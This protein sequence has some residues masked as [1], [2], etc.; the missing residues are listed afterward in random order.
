MCVVVRYFLRSSVAEFLYLPQLR[1]LRA[2]SRAPSLT[3]RPPVRHPADVGPQRESAGATSSS[4]PTLL[5]RPSSP[6][7][8][9]CARA[10]RSARPRCYR[11]AAPRPVS[12]EHILPARIPLRRETIG[13]GDAA[14][15]LSC[16]SLQSPP[17]RPLPP[18]PLSPP[19]QPARLQNDAQG[20]VAGHAQAQARG[21]PGG[22]RSPQVARRSLARP[23]CSGAARPVVEHERPRR[24][25]SGPRRPAVRR[26]HAPQRLR[27]LPLSQRVAD[28]AARPVVGSFRHPREVRLRAAAA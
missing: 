8:L 14:G 6:P 28:G 19:A 24:R 25:G 27:R 16:V 11:R 2:N 10:A 21:D 12:F 4:S 13:I 7:T 17:S 20:G 23:A 3:A 26:G 1:S 15:F 9:L 18:A 22:E 5:P